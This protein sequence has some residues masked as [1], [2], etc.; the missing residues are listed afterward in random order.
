MPGAGRPSLLEVGCGLGY[1][2]GEAFEEGF[3]VSGLE[4]N[5]HAVD[6]LREKYAFP[7]HHGLLYH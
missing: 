7:I 3:V 6:R 2:L 4:Y 5:R 1:F